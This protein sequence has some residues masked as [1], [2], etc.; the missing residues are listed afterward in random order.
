MRQQFEAE[1]AWGLLTSLD[2]HACNPDF[3]RDADKIKQFVIELCDLI[4]MKRYG[5]CQV[6]HFGE[7]PKVEGFSMLQLIE[8]SCISAHFA[9]D[10]NHAY[11]DIFSCK[12]YEPEV[13]EKFAMDFFQA[14]DC[15]KH[16]VLR[17]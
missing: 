2:L 14:E 15:A 1:D 13:V 8:T 17:K 4:E 7:D 12:F 3:I 5:E 9:N 16:V 6:V 10:T 11:L